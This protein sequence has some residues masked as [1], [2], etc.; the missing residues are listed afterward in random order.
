ME[1]CGYHHAV[2]TVG[3]LPAT[4]RVYRYR[5]LRLPVLFTPHD[6]R[7]VSPAIPGCPTARGWL[8]ETCLPHLRLPAVANR[9]AVEDAPGTLTGTVSQLLPRR[10]SL[11]AGPTTTQAT[12]CGAFGWETV[13]LDADFG[14]TCPLPVD[15]TVC[16]TTATTCQWGRPAV[17]GVFIEFLG[18]CSG[19]SCYYRADTN[20]DV[21]V[22]ARASLIIPTPGKAI[23]Y[24]Y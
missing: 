1:G 22:K 19:Y 24:S 14:L 20:C 13:Q 6:P 8:L 5:L 9:I 17:E 7:I 15:H 12:A 2:H 3:H 16:Y 10:T 4:T 11:A 23:T 21:V 18:Y